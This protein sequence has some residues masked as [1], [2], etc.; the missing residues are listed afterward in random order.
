MKKRHLLS[1]LLVVLLIASFAPAVTAQAQDKVTTVTWWA[2]E[3]GRDTAATRQLHFDLAR[4]FEESHPNIKVAIALYPSKG[5]DTRV[6]TAIAAGEGPDVWYGFYAA[7][8]A[9]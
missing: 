9:S 7:D 2:T 4:K 1:L 5:F 6:K 8:V 3:R